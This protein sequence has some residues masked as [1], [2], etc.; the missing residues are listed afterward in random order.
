[1]N[2]NGKSVPG[3]AETFSDFTIFIDLYP[4]YQ[5]EVHLQIKEICQLLDRCSQ[6][7]ITFFIALISFP[8]KPFLWTK[9]LHTFL[10]VM[11]INIVYKNIKAQ[12]H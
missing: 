9:L 6:F 10:F 4:I 2:S 11:I 8:L 12:N 5:I 3:V 1:M 7:S